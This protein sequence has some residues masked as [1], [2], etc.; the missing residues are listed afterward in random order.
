MAAHVQ[1]ITLCNAEMSKDTAASLALGAV[2]M[3][4]VP[5]ATTAS[6]PHG[7]ASWMGLILQLRLPCN[8]HGA[9]RPI[10]ADK[11]ETAG[12]RHGMLGADNCPQYHGM[13]ARASAISAPSVRNRP[14]AVC[15]DGVHV[16]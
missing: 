9:R 8:W 2:S 1:N 3:L 13:R 5:I 11:Q 14:I 6:A 16:L 12:S 4:A 15:A 7:T 10:S